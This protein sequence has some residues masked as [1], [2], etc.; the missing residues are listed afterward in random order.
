MLSRKRDQNEDI[1]ILKY[2]ITVLDLDGVIVS[3]RN[4]SSDYA[5]FYPAE[6][7]LDYID[8]DLVFAQYWT[9]QDHFEMCRKKSIKCAEV[10]VP[11]SISFD[12]VLC[13]VVC[14]ED[15]AEKLKNTG[16]NRKIIVESRAFF[17]S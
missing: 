5:A 4:A 8:F 13:A 12:Y 3:D 9:D 1:C 6:S 16:F 14:S 15:A 7:G 17:R 2:S 11:F 10:L